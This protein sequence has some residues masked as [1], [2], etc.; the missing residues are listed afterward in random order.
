M[1]GNELLQWLRRHPIMGRTPFIM[2]TAKNTKED[3]IEAKEL[4]ADDYII[5]PLTI[6]VLSKKINAILSS[7]P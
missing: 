3:I 4:G 6:E 7:R 1:K 5:K 2:V